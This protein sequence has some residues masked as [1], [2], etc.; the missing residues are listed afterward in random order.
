MEVAGNDCKLNHGEVVSVTLYEGDLPTVLGSPDSI[1]IDTETMGLRPRRDRLCLVQ[2]SVGD[3][4]AHL[5]R[6]PKNRIGADGRFSAPNMT[7]LLSDPSVLKIF[8]FARFDVA[9]LRHY[10]GTD[11]RPIYCTKI[12]SR[13]VR[14]YT[15]CHGLK[16]VCQDL[17]GVNLAKEQQ[18]SDWGANRLS[19]AQQQYAA[20]DVLHLHALKRVLDGMLAR[21][22]RADIAA[23][24]FDF[25]PTLAR[26]DLE[27][28]DDANIFSH[29]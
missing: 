22:G 2:F 21:E 24:C 20:T 6:L 16:D 9:V 19:A 28:W 15:D 14:T 4:T 11:C 10:F 1:A 27:G 18:S 26:L 5:V 7:Q 12:A 25:L 23:A 13:L 29:S 17:L 8:H 3:G